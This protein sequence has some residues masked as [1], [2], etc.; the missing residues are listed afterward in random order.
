MSSEDPAQGINYKRAALLGAAGA[1]T[2]IMAAP[3]VISGIGFGSA[4]ILAGSYAASWMSAAALAGGG[5][6]VKG[7]TIAILQSVGAAGMGATGTAVAGATGAAGALGSSAAYSKLDEKGWVEWSKDSA[8]KVGSATGGA[9]KGA[10]NATADST[11]AAWTASAG[12]RSAAAD[13]SCKAAAGTWEGT[14]W[15]GSSAWNAASSGVGYF[16]KSKL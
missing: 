4:G 5:S 3:L 6:V 8:W 1:T 9:A 14:K 10:W 16:T 12:A 2:A 13:Y 7:S 11:A 15:V